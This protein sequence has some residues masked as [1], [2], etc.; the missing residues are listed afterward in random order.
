MNK[1]I[2]ISVPEIVTEEGWQ[3]AQQH[4]IDNKKVRPIRKNKWLLQGLITCG[5]CGLGLKAEGHTHSRYYS[6]RGRL[7]QYR[8]DGS[9]GCT[10][11]RFKADWLEDQV[12]Q[13]IEAIINDPNKLKPLLEE[14]IGNL[15]NREEELSDKIRPVNE[16]LAEIYEQKAKL[17]DEW[18][19]SNMEPE[20]FQELKRSLD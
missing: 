15:K 18:V 7:K 16:R 9:P 6:C 14:T 20:K 2:T 8:I 1:A 5:E 11:P 17:A 13:R 3:L 4:L 12:W 19:S 10:S